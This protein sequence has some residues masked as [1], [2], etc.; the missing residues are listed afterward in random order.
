VGQ[1]KGKF[2]RTSFINGPKNIIPRDIIP[3]DIS[4]TR[5]T[6]GCALLALVDKKSSTLLH[7]SSVNAKRKYELFKTFMIIGSVFR[8]SSESI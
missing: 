8:I 2:L 6:S 4:L 3:R 7:K 5:A 1:K